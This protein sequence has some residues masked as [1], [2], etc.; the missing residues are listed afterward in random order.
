M[1]LQNIMIIALVISI[2]M[3]I[4]SLIIAYLLIKFCYNK[5][6]NRNRLR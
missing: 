6:N 1:S 2:S 4:L 3:I 5:K